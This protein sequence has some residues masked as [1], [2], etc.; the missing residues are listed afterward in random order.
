MILAVRAW[1]LRVAA[2]DALR[3]GD[4][5]R[6]HALAVEA[7]DAQGSPEGQALRGIGAFL[8]ATGLPTA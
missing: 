3:A 4:F 2:R 5:E 6:A 8:A 1:K 7:Q